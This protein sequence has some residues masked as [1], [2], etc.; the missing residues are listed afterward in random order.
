M[1]PVQVYHSARTMG[2]P[3]ALSGEHS[4]R[5]PGHVWFRRDKSEEQGGR[6]GREQDGD[7]VGFGDYQWRSRRVRRAWRE[8]RRRQMARAASA[9]PGTHWAE[10]AWREWRPRSR[11]QCDFMSGE[12]GAGAKDGPGSTIAST[13]CHVSCFAES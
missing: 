13:Q 9:V 7:G 12:G 8:Q 4:A 5:Q 10:R 1:F 2:T 6:G 11:L 3:S